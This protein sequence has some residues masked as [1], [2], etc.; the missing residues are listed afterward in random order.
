MKIYIQQTLL[1]KSDF[2]SAFYINLAKVSDK[3]IQVQIKI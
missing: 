3:T 2:L 1:L